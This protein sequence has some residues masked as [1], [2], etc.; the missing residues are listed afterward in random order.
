MK[1]IMYFQH[2][3]SVRARTTR[4]ELDV[5]HIFGKAFRGLFYLCRFLRNKKEGSLVLII[6]KNC[7]IISSELFVVK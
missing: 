3:Q 4:G 7:S 6:N 1:N 5:R 2:V